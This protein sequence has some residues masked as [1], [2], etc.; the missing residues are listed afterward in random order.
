MGRSLFM[1]NSRW[2]L[3]RLTVAILSL[4]SVGGCGKGTKAGPPL[5]PARVNLTPS[6]NTSVNLGTTFGFTAS[7]QTAAGTTLATTFTY[8]SSDTSVLTVAPNGVACAGHWDVAFTTCTP[9][10]A[11]VVKVT[12]FALGQ[13][14]VPTYVFVHPVI[15][16]ITVTGILLT[17]V[18]IQEPCLST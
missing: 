4:G 3:L 11:G 18:P 12:A 13:S 16:S 5:F 14:S 1:S 17:G 6:S 8:T 10:G 15:D 2:N 7:A 9:G